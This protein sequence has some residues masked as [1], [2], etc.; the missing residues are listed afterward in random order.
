MTLAAKFS[1]LAIAFALA[2]ATACT[3]IPDEMTVAEYCADAGN[4]DTDVCKLNLEIDGQRQALSRTD[5]SLREARSVADQALARATA[6][7]E[8]A[9]QAMAREDQMFCETR[10]VQRA[11]TGS[12]SPGYTLVGCTQTRYTR[13]A[14]GVSILRE[15]NDE[16]CRFNDPV[17]EM[18]VRCCMA[19]GAARPTEAAAPAT[20]A[21]QPAN[22]PTSS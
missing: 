8:A 2:G 17:L 3:G 21:P 10:T 14:G 12:C 7:Q 15:I 1:T 13:R 18:Q 11:T 16:S 5:M 6:A 20:P 22:D 9:E 19:G 4:A